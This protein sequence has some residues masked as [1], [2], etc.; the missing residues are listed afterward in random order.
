M[1]SGYHWLSAVILIGICVVS[2]F[3]DQL[4][5]VQ[6]LAPL[7]VAVLLLGICRLIPFSRTLITI[8]LFGLSSLLAM[9]MRQVFI[10][11]GFVPM[12]ITHKDGLFQRRLNDTLQE[13]LASWQYVA[14]G[15]T[16]MKIVLVIHVIAA[17]T[18]IVLWSRRARRLSVPSILTNDARSIPM[19]ESRLDRTSVL[20]VALVLLLAPLTNAAVLIVTGSVDPCSVSRYQYTWWFLPLMCLVVWSRLLPGRL[21]RLIPGIVV[22]L[23]AF[24][25]LTFPDPLRLDRLTPRYPPLARALDE[26]VRKHGPLRGFAE[27]WS[28]RE[29]RYLTQE[30]VAVLPITRTGSPRFHAFNP[31]SFLNDDPRDTNVPD[32]HFVIFPIDGK[33]DGPDPEQITVRFG[34][35]VEIIPAGEYTIWR[36]ECMRNRPFDWFLRASG[37]ATGTPRTFPCSFGTGRITQTETKSDI[38]GRSRQHPTQARRS[39]DRPLR[40][41][42]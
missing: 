36:Y 35:P 29:M 32:Y 2:G 1:R 18:V 4:L 39:S 20:L 3:S 5:I 16:L 28:A 37:P 9:K 6:Y 8:A 41:A 14:Q 24:R 11:L 31:N 38:M 22:I 27:F 33:Q 19:G 13:Y 42:C 7:C 30:R 40:E 23:V 25:L 15:Q 26:M 12:H 10:W 34:K 21:P 17:V